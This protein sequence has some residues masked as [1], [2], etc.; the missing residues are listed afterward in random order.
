MALE[1]IR[2]E[3]RD[4]IG[5]QYRDAAVQSAF[6]A[7]VSEANAKTSE[8]EAKASAEAAAAVVGGA[9]ASAAAAKT[10]ETNAK[11]AETNAKTAETNA[12]ASET[13]VTNALSNKAD[14]VH[15]HPVTDI[16]AT[17]TRGS[18]TYLRGDGTWATPTNTTYT[19]PTQAEAEA[20]TATTGR[21][22]SA[23]RVAQ[24]IAALAATKTHTHEQSEV[25]GLDSALAGKA[26]ATH[27]HPVTEITATG[28]RGTTTYLRGDGTWTVP[29]NTTFSAVSQAEAEAGTV[30]TSRVWSAQRVSQAIAAQAAPKTHTHTMAQITDLPT[31]S[32][33]HS[34]NTIA[35]RDGSGHINVGLAPSQINHAASKFYVDTTRKGVIHSGSGS[36][37]TTIP[38]AVAGD[39]WLNTDTME[40]HKITAV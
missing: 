26:D 12:K 2:G 6:Q 1:E 9:S 3:V 39:F 13:T 4:L 31:V 36:V 14:V 23:Q 25:T 28:T 22:F 20:G 5:T 19:V 38:G 10:S 35:Q 18:S 8:L 24:A 11:T 21:A 40:L 29:P 16:T 34:L 7:G 37:P 33:L 17:G 15:T 30:T 27:S 32:S